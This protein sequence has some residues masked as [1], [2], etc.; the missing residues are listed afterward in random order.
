MAFAK[1]SGYTNL[2]NGNFS[3]EIFSKQAQLAFRKSAV[4]SAIT[5]SDYFGEISGQGDSVRI[6]KEPDITVNS[7]LVVLRFQ[8]KI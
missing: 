1:A 2:N 7:C 5:N 6:L 4:V 8:H 3:S